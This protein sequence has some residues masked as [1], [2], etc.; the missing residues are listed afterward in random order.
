M[1]RTDS[2]ATDESPFGSGLTTP[3]DE[4]LQPFAGLHERLIAE[5]DLDLQETPRPDKYQKFDTVDTPSKTRSLSKVVTKAKKFARGLVQS[6][7]ANVF[8]DQCVLPTL[9]LPTNGV[10]INIEQ[11]PSPTIIAQE[12]F[13]DDK[14]GSVLSDLVLANDR[15]PALAVSKEMIEDV[16]D[17]KD[18]IETV[19]SDPHLEDGLKI[20]ISPDS[21]QNI[22]SGS[23]HEGFLIQ[24]ANSVST[25]VAKSL[26]EKPVENT[27]VEIVEKDDSLIA[28]STEFLFDKALAPRFP[29]FSPNAVPSALLKIILFLPWCVLVGATILLSPQHL[30]Y[31]AFFPGYIASPQGI[32][33]F[34]HW[35][36]VAFPHVMIFFAF[37]VC[38]GTQHLLLGITLAALTVGQSIIAWHDFRYDSEIPVGD[39]DRQS[40][41]LVAVTLRCSKSFT[42]KQS[43]RGYFVGCE[44]DDTDTNDDSDTD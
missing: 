6:S 4:D 24:Q 38:I 10:D 18:D 20:S 26:T 29:D 25:T 30:E 14:L 19:S 21:T 5:F 42:L 16:L 15:S 22:P 43:P 7:K 44:E 28:D 3:V 33:R 9:I 12:T 2:E 37:I 27:P 17:S 36:E 31:A 11:Q 39:D 34:A 41:Y 13:S 23:D 35:A 32:C 8:E 40:L 1:Q